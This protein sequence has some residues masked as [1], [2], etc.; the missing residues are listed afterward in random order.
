MLNIIWTALFAVLIIGGISSLFY[1]FFHTH[2]FGFV[3]KIGEKNKVLSWVVCLIPLVIV[4]LFGFIN[5]FAAIIVQLH[6]TVIWIICDLIGFIIRKIRK[7]EKGKRYIS[8]TAA[9]CITVLY[10]GYGWFCAHHVFE[11]DYN[12][13]TSKNLGENLRIALLADSHIGITLDGDEFAN[14][15]KK[16]EKTNPDVLIIAGDYV[17]DETTKSDMIKSCKALGNIKTTYGIYFAYG[18]HD[19]GYY[20][21]RDFSADDLKEELE[22]NNVKILE[23]E[24]VLIDNRFY[25]IGRQD[26][27]VVDRADMDK[28]TKDLDNSKYKILIDHEPN[29]Y[30]NEQGKVD[31]VLSGHTHGG[32]IFPAGP[33]GDL[34]KAN[35]F[36]YGKVNR[37]G[38]DFIVTSGIS[39]WAIPFKTGTISEF[40]IIDIKA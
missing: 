38:T 26:R 23:D 11:T 32:H 27:Q 31:L 40:A 13:E 28:L 6:L 21:A 33:I 19:K 3:K 14:E 1:V 5:I 9:I 36:T 30:D 4:S 12:I 39:G 16:L 15:I 18:N 8:G 35:D 2:K 37:S 7:S 34:L 29:D 20:N 17:D 25:I 24:N 22:K 10:M